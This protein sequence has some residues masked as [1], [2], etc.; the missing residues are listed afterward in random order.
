[1]FLLGRNLFLSPYA[2]LV[3]TWLLAVMPAHISN[4]QVA[5]GYSFSLLLSIL[6]R[7]FAKRTID[8]G[9]YRLWAAF[10]LSELFGA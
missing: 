3:I 6:S 8:E 1:M 4:S 10:G 2:G 7:L 5:R 9:K